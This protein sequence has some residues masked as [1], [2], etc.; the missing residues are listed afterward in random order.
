MPQTLLEM[1]KDLVIEQIRQ[2]QVSI[3]EAQSLLL[4]THSTLRNLYHVET[5]VTDSISTPAPEEGTPADWQHSITKHAVI[6]LECGDSFRQL[7]GRHL[8]RHDLDSKSYRTKHGIPRTQALSA[9]QA[10]ARR[11]EIAQQIRPWEQAVKKRQGVSRKN[12]ATK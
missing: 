3:E 10:T 1:T 2:Y 8:R 9:R 5:S 11:R 4:A 12:T 7:S 6:C